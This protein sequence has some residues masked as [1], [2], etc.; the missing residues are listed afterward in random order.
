MLGH[1]IVR[2]L[3]YCSISSLIYIGAAAGMVWKFK[4][5]LPSFAELEQV[6]PARTT[7]IYS[8]DG[9]ILKRFWVENR[10]PIFY[11]QLPQAAIDALISV[12]DQNF[13]RHWGVSLPDIFRAV[14]RNIVKEGRLK[15]HG[16]STVTQQLARNL[17]LTLDVTWTRKIQEQLTAILLERTYTKREI[18]EIYFN[19]VLFGRGAHGI[20]SAANR[21]FGKTAEEMTP[22]ECALLVGLLR[23]PYFYSPVTHPDRALRRR[24]LVLAQMLRTRRISRSAYQSAVQRPIMLSE[25]DEDIGEAPYFTEYIRQHLEDVYGYKVL[26]EEGVSVYTTLDSRVQEIAEEELQRQLRDIQRDT[27]RKRRLSPPDSA[28]WTGVK[29]RADTFSVTVVQGALIALDPHTGHILAMVGGRDFNESKFNR[30]V[31]APLQPGSAFKPFIYT[32]AI[33][34]KYP[35]TMRFPDTAVSIRMEDGSLWQP[36]NYDRKFLG[37]MTMRQGL[38]R[39]RNVVTTQLLQK[40]GPR[41]V[42]R[43]AKRMGITTPVRPVLSLGMGTSEVK[44]IDL[45]TAYGV[46]P[47]RG[48]HVEPVSILK[49]VDKEGNILEERVQG[50]ENVALGVETAAVMTNMLQSVMDNY[51]EGTGSSARRYPYRFQRPAAG[52]TGTTQN[53]ADAWFVGFTPQVVSGVWIGFDR[54]ISLGSRMSGAV[55]ALPVWATFMKRIH[56]ALS[57]PVEDFE[58]PPT[59]GQ[60]EVCGETYQVASKNCPVRLN[61]VFIPGAEPKEVCPKHSGLVQRPQDKKDQGQSRPFHF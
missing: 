39:S 40:I 29:T 9:Q 60:I 14:L 37:W 50:E 16:A 58:L 46:F 52:K 23:G 3:L 48:I 54:R 55:V 1:Y 38:Y 32:A 56:Q 61:E 43:Y 49:V 21:F 35:P 25:L 7:D 8:A 51:P 57:L 5:G 22:D 44:L 24:N 30:A 31:Q 17:F 4:D 6:A 11:D 13:W 18:I 45:V 15:G 10:I 33:D 27:D 34:N 26:Y 2:I 42:V 53:F 41:T 28:F 20:E 36:E 59:V 19:K 12:E 47:N